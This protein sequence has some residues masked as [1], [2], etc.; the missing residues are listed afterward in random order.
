MF[1]RC[2]GSSARSLSKPAGLLSLHSVAVGLVAVSDLL[3]LR[4]PEIGALPEI[5]AIATAGD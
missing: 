5:V 4:F 3:L 1:R 2:A